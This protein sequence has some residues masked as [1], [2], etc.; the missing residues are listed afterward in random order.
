MTQARLNPGDFL[1]VGFIAGMWAGLDA[2]KRSAEFASIE[3]LQRHAK[4]A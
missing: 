3:E 1:K 4:S 2:R